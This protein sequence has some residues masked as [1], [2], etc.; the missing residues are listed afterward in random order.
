MALSTRREPVE[1]HPLPGAEVEQAAAA[2][3]TPWLR[4]PRWLVGLA[5]VYLAAPLV[6]FMLTWLQPSAYPA[7]ALLVTCLGV[8]IVLQRPRGDGP[9]VAG[10][11]MVAVVAGFGLVALS[12]VLTPGVD[13][14]IDWHKHAAILNTLADTS[15]P[16]RT[17]DGGVLR[18][19]TGFYLVPA[20]LAR[21]LGADPQLLQGLWFLL[22][23]VLGLLLLVSQL[24]TRLAAIAAAA[25]AVMSGWDVVGCAVTASERC[26]T[27][28]VVPDLQHLEWWTGIMPV[29]SVF[30]SLTWRPS[31]LIPALILLPL[32]L[33]VGRDR[34]AGWLLAPLLVSTVFW[35]PFLAVALLPLVIAAALPDLLRGR[36][37]TALAR[38]WALP[39]LL[40]LPAALLLARYLTADAASIPFATIWASPP[41]ELPLWPPTV[42]VWPNT[43]LLVLALEVLPLVALAALIRGGLGRLQLTCLA[44]TSGLLLVVYGAYNDLLLNGTTPFVLIFGWQAAYALAHLV[45]GSS[46]ATMRSALRLPERRLHVVRAAAVAT[47]LVG[48]WTAV[49]EVGA[50]LSPEPGLVWAECSIDTECIRDDLRYQYEAPVD[51]FP[52]WL[53]RVEGTAQNSAGS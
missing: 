29:N 31:Q 22:G 27:G 6:L 13:V 17:P 47:V 52:R 2:P 16:T 46:A 1:A 43:L 36:D 39:G 45:G 25:L 50:S 11:V 21:E 49:V 3:S 19:Y 7:L 33:T 9:L 32:L 8:G 14:K 4:A 42:P 40:A 23:L 10:A 18:Y 30:T 34:R 28:G 12:G 5:A 24:P 51:A 35:A 53:L 15:W 38:D 44:V 20:L 37:W 48:A 26:R 41:P